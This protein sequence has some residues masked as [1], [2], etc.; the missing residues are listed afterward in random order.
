MLEA[1]KLLP[2][3]T[4]NSILKTLIQIIKFN[5]KKNPKNTHL[6]YALSTIELELRFCFLYGTHVSFSVLN[7]ND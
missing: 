6:L 3:K 5:E 2:R 1:R 7:F 4:S